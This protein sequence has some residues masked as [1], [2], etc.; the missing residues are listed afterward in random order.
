MAALDKQ[1]RSSEST[2]ESE[3][4]GHSR[5]AMQ[6]RPPVSLAI[7]KRWEMPGEAGPVISGNEG[8]E[9]NEGEDDVIEGEGHDVGGGATSESDKR[10]GLQV[11]QEA[12]LQRWPEQ[13]RLALNLLA[14]ANKY[15]P[16]CEG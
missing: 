4:T 6:N 3:N 14:T 16:Y 10:N 8:A 15:C 9:S 5:T 13:R 12:T 11:G 1:K 2:P 7:Q